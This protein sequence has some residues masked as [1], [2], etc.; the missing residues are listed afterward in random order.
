MI[1]KLKWLLHVGEEIM[2]NKHSCKNLQ[3]LIKHW[4]NLILLICSTVSIYCGTHFKY[5]NVR[6]I[7]HSTNLTAHR[8]T[9][10]FYWLMV[11]FCLSKPK[12]TLFNNNNNNKVF[13]TELCN[14]LADTFFQY[15]NSNSV[16]RNLNK[17]KGST[18]L[19]FDSYFFLS[20]YKSWMNELR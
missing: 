6:T 7:G 20:Q 13:R 4:T 15:F 12:W 16:R 3:F 19:D 2:K 10:G 1:L 17:Y 9:S 14:L 11:I 18:V 8:C 5:S